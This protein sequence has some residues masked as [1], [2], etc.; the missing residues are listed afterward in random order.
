MITRKFKIYPKMEIC[1]MRNP[2]PINNIH[3]PIR[4][5]VQTDKHKHKYTQAHTIMAP[6]NAKYMLI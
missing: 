5:N 3:M 1:T 6:L 4:M 2:I